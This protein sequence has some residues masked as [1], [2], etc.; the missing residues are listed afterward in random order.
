MTENLKILIVTHYFPP[1][2]KM[3]S[4][5]TY[6]WAKYWSRMGHEVCVLTT[7]KE[8]F[9]GISNLDIDDLES[10]NIEEVPYWYFS[11]PKTSRNTQM[12][13]SRNRELS[14]INKL[15]SSIRRLRS[16]TGSIP[17]IHDLWII[18]GVINALRIYGKWRFNIVVSS[19]SP[20]ASHIIAG[21]LKRRLGIF[22]VADY[23]DL[24][25]GNH[26]QS[27]RWPFSILEKNIEDFWVKK[28]DLI[29]VVSEPLAKKLKN[30]FGENKVIV[31]ENGFDLEDLGK[32]EKENIFSE[33]GKIRIVYTGTIYPN[34]RDPSPIFEA[35]NILRN[36]GFDIEKKLEIIFYGS[37]LGNLRQLIDKY[38]VAN[39]I[40][41]P[42]LVDRKTSIN[43]QRSAD[44]LLFLEWEDPSVDGILTGK[45]FEYMF[46]GKPILGIGITSKSLAGKIIEESGTGMALGK[47]VGKIAEVLTK[48]IN[49]EVLNYKPNIDLIMKY[50]RKDLAEKMLEEI[51]QRM[52]K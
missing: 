20:P 23:R 42:G 7:K 39:I 38:Q 2:N 27:S 26:V 10:V 14:D 48:L 4:L 35:V 6:S 31:V 49:G 8:V 40:K 44:V 15:K 28:A 43:A 34:K 1:L 33:D 45:L 41:T 18:P 29:T 30:R 12:K 25:Y 17:D 52:V 37:D 11:V 51:L 21:I 36:V 47:D 50:T 3:G 24:W 32:I 16:F 5:R 19:Y 13:D 9:D 22:W 46:S